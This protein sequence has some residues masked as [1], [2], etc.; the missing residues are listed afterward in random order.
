MKRSIVTLSALCLTVSL[1]AQDVNIMDVKKT[2]SKGENPGLE[3]S[4]PNTKVVDVAKVFE[5]KMKDYKGK[6]IAPSKGNVEYF[7]DDAK[8]SAISDQ[9]V[10]IYA[11]ILPEGENVKFTSFYSV[12][13]LFFSTSNEAQYAIAKNMVAGVYKQ[14]M[15]DQMEFNFIQFVWFMGRNKALKG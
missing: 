3:V 14:V 12:G 5:S 7:I 1:M 11:Y 8:I 2:M 4:I 10:D 15:F 13:G 6:F 9:P